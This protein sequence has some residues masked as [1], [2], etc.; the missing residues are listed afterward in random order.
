M[1]SREQILVSC[2]HGNIYTS[3]ML[4]TVFGPP[5]VADAEETACE[6]QNATNKSHLGI[7]HFNYLV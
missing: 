1:R 6:I 5:G 4:I 3:V 7:E 2:F